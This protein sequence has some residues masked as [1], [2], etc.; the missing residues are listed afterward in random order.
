MQIFKRNLLN[1]IYQVFGSYISV[2]LNRNRQYVGI[3]VILLKAISQMERLQNVI[4][5]LRVHVVMK[6]G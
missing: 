5:L 1:R 3:L 6:R 2:S 4:S